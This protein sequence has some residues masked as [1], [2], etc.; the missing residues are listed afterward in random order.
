MISVTRLNA[1][2]FVL[3]SDLIDH[4]DSNPDTVITLVSGQKFIVRETPDMIISRIIEFRRQLLSETASSP[5]TY[6]YTPA[7]FPKEVR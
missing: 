1:D 3:N 6:R 5:S 2:K 7:Q 4:I